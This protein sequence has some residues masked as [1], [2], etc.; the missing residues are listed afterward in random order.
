MSNL[1]RGRFSSKAVWSLPYA[2]FFDRLT[3]NVVFYRISL[4]AKIIRMFSA[5]RWSGWCL[6]GLAL[7]FAGH[8]FPPAPHYV[9]YGLV[10]DQVGATLLVEGAELV[11]LRNGIEIGRTPVFS[12]L[13]GDFNYE[14]KIHIDQN[15]PSTRTYSEKAVPANGLYS[16]VVEMNG[17]KFYPINASGNLQA[18]GGGERVR[19]DLNLGVDSDHDGLPDAW[20]E[21][22]M[23]QAG[24]RPGP[25]GWDLSLI[26]RNGDF[27]GDGISNYDEYIAGTFAGDAA[28]R[29]ELRI[30]T[31]V[32]TGIKFEFFAITGK[33]YSIE[34]SSDLKTWV[35]IVFRVGPATTGALRYQ[36]PAVDIVNATVDSPVATS[37]FYRLSV[38]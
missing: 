37:R 8:A 2:H 11:L 29:F 13:K 5:V 34:E 30:I 26:T 25:K 4:L 21:W 28:E 33:L 36:A 16:I 17:E 1:N 14:L 7:P 10:R 18:G 22:Q 6:L 9:I 32:P 3:V 24:L 35:P 38:R 20:E 23:Y 19:L 15:R 12:Q 31:K 27:D